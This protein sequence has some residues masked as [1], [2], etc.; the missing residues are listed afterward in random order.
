MHLNVHFT[1]GKHSVGN[2]KFAIMKSVWSI[3]IPLITVLGEGL[4]LMASS[5]LRRERSLRAFA[6]NIAFSEQL[7]ST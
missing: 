5:W 6:K 4:N 1:V 2:Y 7:S 3:F